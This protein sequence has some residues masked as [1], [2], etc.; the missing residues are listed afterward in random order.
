MYEDCFLAY[1][2]ILGFKDKIKETE[3]NLKE[4]KTLIE[5]LKI[6]TKF[7]Q[8]GGKKT[9]ASGTLEIR[10]FFFSDSFLFMM[11]ANKENLPH[12]FL[13]IR[14]LQDRLWE[15]KLCLRGAMVKGKMYWPNIRENIILGPAMIKAYKLES[16][17]AIYPRIIVSEDLYR[18]IKD[19]KIS[20]YPVSEEGEL[21]EFIKKDKDGVYFFDILNPNILRKKGEKI[22]TINERENMIDND[23]KY[24]KSFSI[25]W[26]SSEV[27]N[28]ENI[29]TTVKEIVK[30][31][32]GNQN[33]VVKQKYS[34]LSYYL[35]EVQE[36]EKEGKK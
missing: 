36:R 15:Y 8:S 19:K 24:G 31:S 32:K 35:E 34:W 9:T 30:N 7:T 14:Y 16:E 13:I 11:K 12:L 18:Y 33:P 4:L 17:V 29:I 21:K 28:Y 5:A 20:A 10:S 25:T 3:I 6:N 1:L 27:S 2:D 26:N 22:I 23:T